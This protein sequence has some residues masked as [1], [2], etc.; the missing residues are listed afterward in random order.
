MSE[1]VI[2]RQDS[3]FHLQVWAFDPETAL[4]EEDE[5]EEVS[6]LHALTP[7]GMMLA[8]LGGCTAIV[9]HTY[10]QHHNLDLEQVTLDLRYRRDFREDCD[11][12]EQTER[13]EERIE[14]MIRLEG[15]LDEPQRERLFKIAH[16]CPIYKM[17]EQGIEIASQLQHD[18]LVGEWAS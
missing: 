3:E 15:D 4:E 18:A 11:N 6:R 17:F 9:V 10:A 8:S 5:P 7:Y 1:H 14:E 12:C 16:Q 13:Y 2:V